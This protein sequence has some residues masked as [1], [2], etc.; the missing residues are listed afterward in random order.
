MV[1]RVGVER[2]EEERVE[3]DYKRT[4]CRELW[5]HQTRAI[6]TVDLRHGCQLSVELSVSDSESRW[7]AQWPTQSDRPVKTA[8]GNVSRRRLLRPTR[9]ATATS[10]CE[11]TRQHP[12]VLSKS[13]SPPHRLVHCMHWP[14]LVLTSTDS[15]T[16]EK[17]E[18]AAL[19]RSVAVLVLCVTCDD[20]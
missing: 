5:G 15:R 10:V 6:V 13:S 12:E 8:A 16:G 2:E 18:A 9:R 17:V 19:S 4:W 3:R 7:C 11:V 20:E 14:Q 1:V